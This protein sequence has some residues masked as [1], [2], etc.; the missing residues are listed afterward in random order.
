VER[1]VGSYQMA[2]KLLGFEP[3]VTLREGLEATWRWYQQSLFR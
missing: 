2:R 3:S 1:N